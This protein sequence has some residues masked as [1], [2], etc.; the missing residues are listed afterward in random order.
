[1]RVYRVLGSKQSFLDRGQAV[2]MSI[3]FFAG[4]VFENIFFLFICPVV[5]FAVTFIIREKYFGGKPEWWIYSV[6]M[7][8]GENIY[9]SRHLKDRMELKK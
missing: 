2:L 3:F 8:R 5:I 1:M 4:A 6:R 9:Y 7:L